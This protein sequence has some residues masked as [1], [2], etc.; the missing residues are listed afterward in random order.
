MPASSIRE[1][2]AFDETRYD[3]LKVGLEIERAELY[4]RIE[5]RVDRMMEHGFVEEVRLLLER[6]DP[7]AQPFA[8]VGY[9]EIVAHL[10]GEIGLGD[11][12][13]L[14]KQ[15]TR[16]LAKRQLTWFRADPGIRWFTPDDTGSISKLVEAFLGRSQA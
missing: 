15:H 11:A 6:Y 14:V 13:K 12:V 8:A 7:S 16:N 5:E 2:H 10:K 1:R 4:R 3:A 9:K